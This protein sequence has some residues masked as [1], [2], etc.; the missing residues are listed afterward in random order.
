[1]VMFAYTAAIF[2]VLLRRPKDQNVPIVLL[3]ASLRLGAGL[4]AVWLFAGGGMV[5]WWAMF[6]LFVGDQLWRSLLRRRG[7]LT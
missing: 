7:G 5:A 1:M 2:W 6:G 4:A 3:H